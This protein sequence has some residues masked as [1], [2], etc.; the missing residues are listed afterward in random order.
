MLKSGVSAFLALSFILLSGSVSAQS[1][2]VVTLVTD[3]QKVGGFLLELTTE[4]F[5]RV[6]YK[7][8]VEFLPWPRA[9]LM[10]YD[11]R[12][13]A[14]LGCWYSDERAERLIYSEPLAESPLVFFALKKSHITYSK[15]EDLAGYTIAI[16]FGSVYP[17]EF[18]DATFLKIDATGKDYIINLHRLVANRI[19][20]F[21]EKKYVVT[22]Y[23]A[24]PAAA[25]LR[26]SDIVALDPPLLI[27]KYYNGFSKM[28][29]DA[30][31]K[32]S[33][34]NKGLQM[35][36]DDGTYAAIMSKNLHE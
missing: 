30:A 24:S 23:L 21:V 31:E 4:A 2:K 3:E 32:L 1:E 15:L 36:K 17:K 34:F 33:A 19:D 27:S 22:S 11:G 16:T 8:E 29:P 6:G 14:L 10:A 9:V 7:A 12:A 13:D 25:S 28:K 18:I 5:K 26:N 35:I 20:L